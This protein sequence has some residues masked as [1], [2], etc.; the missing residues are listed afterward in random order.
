[1]FHIFKKYAFVQ[2]WSLSETETWDAKLLIFSN[3]AILYFHKSG[4]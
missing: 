4:T 1:M 3:T 2:Y